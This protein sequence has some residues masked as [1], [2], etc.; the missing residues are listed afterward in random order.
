MKIDRFQIDAGLVSGG[1]LPDAGR[2]ALLAEAVAFFRAGGVLS[3]PDWRDMGDET[4]DV[5]VEARE[6][7][8]YDRAQALAILLGQPVTMPGT[9]APQDAEEAALIASSDRA[10][11]TAGGTA[12]AP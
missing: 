8:E 11:A 9:A 6:A 4:R 1:D 2:A 12:G 3:W 5:F 7:V 10:F